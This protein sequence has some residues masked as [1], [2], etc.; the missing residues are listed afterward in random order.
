MRQLIHPILLLAITLFGASRV[1]NAQLAAEHPLEPAVT[2][3]P[4]AT[5]TTF[6]ETFR[7]GYE[8][9]AEN[10][11]SRAAVSTRQREYLNNRIMGCLDLSEVPPAL[12]LPTA[13]E[14]ATCLKEVLDRIELPPES[15]W[16]DEELV[17]EES[18]TR[19][20]IPHTE[21]TIAMAETGE[22]KGK[23]LFT[24]ETIARAPDFYHRVQD[25]PYIDRENSTPGVFVFFHAEPGTLLP[26]NF[27]KSLP[28]WAHK[29][30]AGQAVWQWFA[31][32][33]VLVA[34]LLTMLTLYLIG[35]RTGRAAQTQGPMRYLLTLAFPFAAMFV[36]MVAHYF[37]GEQLRITGGVLI[38]LTYC[39]DILFLLAAVVLVLG[40][41][42]RLTALI[43][44]APNIKPGGMD[45]QFVRLASRII[46]I[47]AAVVVMLE[48]GQRIGI[49]LSTL[50]TGA[51][52]GGL[53]L[54]LAAQDMLKN[55]FGTIMISLDKPYRVGERIVVKGYD[56]IVEEVGLRSTKIRTL[57]GHLTSIPNEEMARSDVENIGRR[58]S[59]R[60][61]TDI[62][63]PLDTPPEKVQQA[64]EILRGLLDN[65]EGFHEDYPPRVFFNEF[66]R[67]SLNIRVML[68]Y[69][70]ANY[71]DFLAF[72][73]RINQQIVES[74]QA[75]DIPFAPPTNRT[76]VA[77][78][79]DQSLQL[80]QG[81]SIPKEPSA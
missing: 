11:M 52:V 19:W 77:Q 70:P 1:A 55:V 51:G 59:I 63:I 40:A 34:A 15:E 38:A 24:P 72:S 3:S 5:L 39:L 61:I 35:I 53:A 56:G 75:D 10:G 41:G 14:A 48:G 36:P 62:A 74:F 67:D 47:F 32:I 80:H 28:E 49:P 17:Q 73:Q 21:I 29:R 2:T 16:P 8:L 64:V 31:L 12:K 7:E 18:I 4:R 37:I 69:H 65:H 26:R 46:S 25:L 42:S 68:W 43:V 54:A 57:T 30:P 9:I 6:L 60:R 50:L 79:D 76:F 71:W 58:R 66:N 13:D 22:Q 81:E 20:T 44:A 78:A 23:F 33:V 45:A 27:I